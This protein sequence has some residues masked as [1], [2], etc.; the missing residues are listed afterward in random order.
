MN[1]NFPVQ[2]IVLPGM[3][4]DLIEKSEVLVKG[5]NDAIVKQRDISYSAPELV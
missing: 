4:N 5:M 2:R 3:V 1:G